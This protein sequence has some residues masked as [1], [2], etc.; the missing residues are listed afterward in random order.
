MNGVMRPL[1]WL[2]DSKDEVRS[3]P[4]EVRKDVG[5]ALFD[6]Q[7]GVKPPAAKPLTG[8]GSGIFEIVSPFDTN[9]YRVV[10]AVKIGSSVYVLDAFQKKSKSGKAIPPRDLN[11]IKKRYKRAVELAREIEG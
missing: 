9:T 7:K 4:E 6:A 5:A 1:V 11:R 2:G 10:Y 8:I 3:F